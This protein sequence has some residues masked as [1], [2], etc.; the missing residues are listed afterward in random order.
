M[1]GQYPIEDFTTLDLSVA[2][3]QKTI[4]INNLVAHNLLRRLSFT[5]DGA[6]G[7][8]GLGVRRQALLVRKIRNKKYFKQIL[9][10]VLKELKGMVT[11]YEANK[12]IDAILAIDEAYIFVNTVRLTEIYNFTPPAYTYL[13]PAVISIPSSFTDEGRIRRWVAR[14]KNAKHNSLE[15][16]TREFFSE[17][18]KYAG[19]MTG[20]IAVNALGK[21]TKFL[22][23]TFPV[24]FGGFPIP[25]VQEIEVARSGKVVK[26]RATGSVF[27]AQQE[28]GEDAIR[29]ECLLL[30]EENIW[31]LYLWV[32]FL[33]GKGRTRKISDLMTTGA[34]L[35][36]IRALITNISSENVNTT[37][38][39]YEYHMTFPL[40]TRHII[41][42]NVYI[43]T[44]SFED[45]IV[46]GLNVLKVSILLRT[47]TKPS[48]F[49]QYHKDETVHYGPRVDKTIIMY[50]VLEFMANIAW[51]CANMEGIIIGES[52]LFNEQSFKTGL[53]SSNS[54][55]VYYDINSWDIAQTVALGIFGVI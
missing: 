20:F 53:D 48:T 26:F 16:T 22:R 19:G 25:H 45:R 36:K 54:D 32:L 9:A 29:V 55:D 10:L 46:D 7:K 18:G 17:I 37:K 27:L 52:S 34:S 15:Y 14:R 41:L 33:W 4:S 51:R 21:D 3:T 43:E 38:P 28:G 47:Y 49:M 39:S 35:N 42:T 50:K 8:K 5:T 11:I 13:P 2:Q 40:V 24:M 23:Y 6:V 12:Y 44:L 1:T 30:P 31:L